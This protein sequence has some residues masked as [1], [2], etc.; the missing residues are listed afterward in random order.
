MTEY[1]NA[2]CTHNTVSLADESRP[3][4]QSITWGG[5]T[6]HVSGAG[7]QWLSRSRG[8]S[9]HYLAQAFLFL[10]PGLAFHSVPV[11]PIIP[12]VTYTFPTQI[13]S[14]TQGTQAFA[15][16]QRIDHG[17]LRHTRFRSPSSRVGLLEH[18]TSSKPGVFEPLSSALRGFRTYPDAKGVGAYNDIV[19][20]RIPKEWAARAEGSERRLSCLGEG[21]AIASPFSPA[22]LHT[23]H[24]SCS[25]LLWC[26]ARTQLRP[27]Y[28][29]SSSDSGMPIAPHVAS[30]SVMAA[31]V[32]Q[33]LSLS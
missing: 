9:S 14:H 32:D 11:C 8:H 1:L 12:P 13:D 2:Q 21:D 17:K 22:F 28:S 24:L 15:S 25:E 27:D 7:P 19:A 33:R 3:T 26:G 16:S 20:D 5:T 30:H 31:A 10:P 29:V 6:G 18:T 4:M 23:I